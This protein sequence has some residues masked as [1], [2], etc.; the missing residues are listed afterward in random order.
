MRIEDYLAVFDLQL[1]AD[2]DVTIKQHS[3]NIMSCFVTFMRI[4]TGRD[5]QLKEVRFIHEAPRDIS[6]YQR[7]FR[8]PLVFKQPTSA[9]LLER[10]YL[11]LP[12][13]QP[14]Q[15]L[16]VLFEEHAKEL[17]RQIGEQHF[18]SEKVKTLFKATHSTLSFCGVP[19]PWALI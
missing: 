18:Y 10:K 16:L 13:I 7:I 1:V 6:D 19:V 17:L 8:A 3:E 2:T 9:L 4:L 5:I 11:D 15:Q 12:I 14:N